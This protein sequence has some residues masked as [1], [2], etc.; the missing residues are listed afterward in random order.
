MHTAVPQGQLSSSRAE[1]AL[2]WTRSRMNGL[3]EDV[4]PC[5]M[6]EEV[7]AE[8]GLVRAAG[9]AL[10]QAAAEL[11]GSPVALVLTDHAARIVDFQCAAGTI[12][13]ALR[14][15]GIARGVCLGEDVIGTNA[16]GTPAEI[17]QGVL[18]RGRE[19]Y[20][21]AFRD[22]TC[23]GHPIFHPVT[24]RL[25]G[26]L[27]I[28]GLIGED[29]RL[30]VPLA[31][32]MVRD[33]EDRLQAGS[34][35]AQTRLM[36]AFQAA[37][38]RRGRCVVVIGEGVVLASPAA[39]DLLEA[40]DHAVIRACAEGARAGGERSV[41]I[42][43]A[44][45]RPVRLVCTPVDRADGVLVDIAPEKST[46]TTFSGC[47]P[48]QRQWPLIVVGEAGTGRTSE[49]RRAAGPRSVT[50][51]ATDVVLRGDAAWANDAR[52]A[53]SGDGPAVI[54]EN[55]D[56]LSEQMT[57]L[58]ARLVSATPRRVVMTST[59]GDHLDG[60]HAPLL[61]LCNDR[62]DLVPLRR[63]R[64]EIPQLAQQ[65]MDEMSAPGRIRLTAETV[66]VLVAQPW[67]GNI[68][69]LRRVVETVAAIRSAGDVI[70][71]D[72]PVSHRGGHRL[73]SPLRE[74]EREIIVAAL[75]AANG[76]KL[77]AARALGVSRST[78]YNRL[79]ALRIA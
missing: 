19:H 1:I 62:A 23:Y 43:L 79:R 5:L 40:A 6:P 77:Q 51:D 17:R 22:F 52:A 55:I 74:A 38:S 46:G 15:L 18:V 68:A 63:R 11:D 44:S 64:H 3:R 56:L 47:E 70:P 59:P 49:A 16:L 20:A 69:E 32:R 75:E 76:N 36:S 78:L 12:R 45:G 26:V 54:V 25:E 29:D 60:V 57:A 28:G 58:L 2:S 8:G 61:S 53:L 71:S 50:F 4:E 37:A 33:I 9:R 48:D 14:D 66:R 39:L 10:R 30:P 41:S 42:T 31:R 27:A 73:G 24:R 35:R 34:P 65:I 72:L 21:T 67:R 13:G 7:D